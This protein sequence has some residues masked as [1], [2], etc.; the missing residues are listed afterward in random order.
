VVAPLRVR[1]FGNLQVEG[2][3]LT[4]LGSRK[5]RTLL[6]LLVL[7]RGEPVSV[8][9]ICDCLW[10]GQLP[11]RPADQVGVL[12]SRIRAVLGPDR[13]IR[14]DGGYA[15]SA[16]WIDL[17]AFEALAGEAQRRLAED[18]PAAAATAA[19]AGLALAARPL[20]ADEPDAPWADEARRPVDR[21][22]SELRSVAA[23]ASLATGDP[24]GAASAAQAILDQD[25]YDEHALRLLMTAHALAGR[26][27]A[28][29]AAYARTREQLEEGL[30]AS[31]SALTDD[32]HL[33]ILRDEI[34]PTPTPTPDAGG[35]AVRLPGRDREWSVLDDSLAK[36]RGR[37]GMILIEGEAGIGKT[38]LLEEWSASKIGAT[39]LWGTCD[40]I[41]AALPFQPVLD[42]LDRHLTRVDERQAEA[43]LAQAGP[44][45]G[46][47]LPGYRG[48]T[49]VPDPLTAQA[50]LFGAALD[51][52][53]LSAAE[54][55]AVLVLDDVH[56]A[57]A[58][59]RA[60]LGFAARRPEAGSLLIAASLR[61]EAALSMPGVTR[62]T[63][64]PLDLASAVRIVGAERAAA[65]LERSA[66]NPLFLVE[67]ANFAGDDSD[68]LPASILEAVSAR[69]AQAGAAEQTL[70]TAAVLGPEIDLDLLAGVMQGSAVNLLGDL[71]EG[72]RLLILEERGL[73]FGFRHELV[74]EA[75]VAGTGATR[76]AL[77]HRQAAQLLAARPRWDPLLVA[78]HA[79]QGGNL[80][81]AANALV[82]AAAE[83]STRFDHGEAERLLGDS[84]ALF[85]LAAAYL[86]R[87]RVRLT[88]E[89]F[90]EA[91]ADAEE[92]LSLGAH[93]ES[94]EL[95]SWSAYYQ[96]HFDEARTLCREAQ[97]S[98]G[99][100]DHALKASI[101]ALGGRIA[102]AD[103]DLQ[104]AQDSLESAVSAAPLRDGVGVGKVWL[105]WLMTDRGYL[106]GSERLVQ[107]V[108][109]DPSLS[110][111]PFAPA[112]RALLAAYSSGLRGRIAEA[113]S[114]LD[115]VDHEVDVR[116]LD[117]FAGRTANY[118]AWLLRNLL[119]ES[120]ADQLNSLA[121]EV[122]SARGLREAQVQ[123]ALDTADAHFRKGE[124]TDA[125]VALD[126]VESLGTG[127]AFDW[128]AG[129][130]RDLLKAR[131]ALGEGRPE[132]AAAMAE[133]LEIR[134]TGLRI[135]RYST[136]ALA[137]AIRARGAAGRRLDPPLAE[138]LLEALVRF[139][140]PEAWWVTAELARDLRIDAWWG[141][142][143]RMVGTLV[144]GAGPRGEEFGRQAG[145]WLDRTRSSRR[146][147]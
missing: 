93:A 54:D 108:A 14:S 109:D 143:D 100:D 81:L 65:L 144:E 96:R 69:G 46:P 147:D 47:L 99:T 127:F 3:D 125:A 110:S 124:L 91:T 126:H 26:P 88:T 62:L 77:A 71:E 119:F 24:F 50:A 68:D 48:P 70:R 80:E 82:R 55:I 92:A 104:A 138:G 9:R 114:H 25:P 76:R 107:E 16:D 83:A 78:T 90:S 94:L 53:C 27:G 30:G 86:A 75:L 129:L 7:G 1:V 41:G 73:A 63:L 61:P 38:R 20:L 59:T 36:A 97:S 45:L 134:A 89:Q 6:R 35:D 133:A 139:A 66:G 95:A 121:A 116:H 33:A 135:P 22:V 67:L 141:P 18:Q 40:P 98:L 57:D 72:Q 106:E 101:L 11:S 87:G 122:A 29:L 60:W 28:A 146:S 117:H 64:G 56:L 111:H 4:S 2:L 19:E 51:L 12:V 49:S 120:E 113:L 32:L 102:H 128:K 123:A 31:P 43:L 21:T 118:R 115:T 79:R 105:G 136:L 42:A 52:C 23:Q 131:L 5:Q 74:R 145:R 84:L 103:G 142:V 85:P 17:V 37:V 130:R 15:L 13:V 112:H 34:G 137:L 39:V 140:A 8:D 10:P 44:V 132:D 58:T